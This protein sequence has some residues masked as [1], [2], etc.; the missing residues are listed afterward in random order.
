MVRPCN[1][2]STCIQARFCL[3]ELY[4]GSV[5]RS[6]A[7]RSI[8]IARSL[9]S[10]SLLALLSAL[11]IGSPGA[12]TA[13]QPLTPFEQLA[14]AALLGGKPL[15]KLTLNGSA[16]WTTGSLQENGNVNLVAGPDGSVT[17]TWSLPTQSHSVT[18]T[19]F[20]AGKSCSSTDQ[21]GKQ[22]QNV[23]ANCLQP[24]S[25]FAPW[26]GLNLFP[27]GTVLSITD[28][29]QP[30]DTASGIV[31]LRFTSRLNGPPSDTAM[32]AKLNDLAS[33]TA[34]DVSFDLKTALPSSL[35]YNYVLDSD[36]AHVIEYAV[37]FTDYRP[38]Q[39]FVL[40]HRIQRYVQRTLQADITIT[41]VTAN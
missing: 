13:Q 24:V 33:R 41:S 1:H 3:T 34:V 29:T 10:Y 20:A 31:K 9:L 19:S 26:V 27:S 25:W 6:P 28:A 23:T 35:T 17:E 16:T 40:P 5:H 12:A 22:H 32:Q 4:G 36:P 37:V 18:E 30:S 38:E 39:G 15:T 8:S 21:A 11:L 7:R 14:L 2:Q